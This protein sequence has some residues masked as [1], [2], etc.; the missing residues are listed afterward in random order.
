M[1]STPT[2]LINKQNKLVVDNKQ[3]A[4][5]F[6]DQFKGVFS[7]P[8]KTTLSQ[9]NRSEINFPLTDLDLT[10]ADFIVAINGLKT[11][12]RCPRQDIPAIILKQCKSSLCLPLRLFWSKSFEYSK[13]PDDYKNQ[14]IIPLHKKGLKTKAENFRP[15]SLTA[16][17]IKLFEKILKKK[18]VEYLEFNNIFNNNQHGFRKNR[19]C[20]TQLLSHINNIL[21]NS[22]NGNETDCIYIDF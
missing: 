5:L 1:S 14:V 13:I 11:N 20:L 16:H 19:S 10:D 4:D 18:L 6:Q 21:N 12:S 2:L 15:I 3:I 7:V 8:S 22:L 9:T 17:V